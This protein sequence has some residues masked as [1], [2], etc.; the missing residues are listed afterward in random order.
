MTR[1]A[2]GPR[3]HFLNAS[4]A[5]LLAGAVAC[6]QEPAPPPFASQWQGHTPLPAVLAADAGRP[7]RSQ[8]LVLDTGGSGGMFGQGDL[9]SNLRDVA[10]WTDGLHGAACGDA[11]AFYTTDGGLSWKRIRRHPRDE[12]PDETSVIYYGI[13][14]AGPREIWLTEGKHPASGRHLWHSTD[15]GQTWEDAAV[16]FGD[17]FPAVWD[18]VVRGRDILMLSGWEPDFSYYSRDGGE[19]WQRLVILPDFEPYY[20][21]TPVAA[22]VEHMATVYV[23][24]ARRAPEA[25]LPCLARSDDTGTTWREVPLPEPERLP[26]VLHRSAISFATADMGW[27]SL[28]PPG[29]ELVAHGEWRKAPGS[30]PAVLYTGDGGNTW[31]RRAL[32]GDEW[33]VTALWLCPEGRGF[34]SVWN[35][36]VRDPGGPRNGPALYETSDAGESWTVALDGKKHI[37]AIFGLD[38]ARIWAVGDVPGF[39][40]NDLVAIGSSA[41]APEHEQQEP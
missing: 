39:A 19:T 32:P 14:M 17:R 41:T 18:L 27:I 15:A 34:A 8:W 5:A 26:W 10:F 33:L 28:T 29:L 11:G 4:A 23:L 31:Q 24:G 7:D 9:R 38:A 2:F 40:A 13:E 16:R 37:N 35:A 30:G 20:G 36:F 25:R 12:Y 22:G 21:C 3:Q 6:S 1:V